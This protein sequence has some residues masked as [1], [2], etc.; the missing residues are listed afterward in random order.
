M[1]TYSNEARCTICHAGYDWKDKNYDFTKAGNVDCLSCHDTTGTYKKVFPAVQPDP[2]LDLAKLALSV[3]PTSRTSCGSCHFYGG[4]GDHIKHGDLDKSLVKPTRDIDVHM[5]GSSNMGC[6]AC[7]S[8]EKHV[9]KGQSML[10]S[11]G[12]GPRAACTDCHNDPKIHKNQFVEKHTKKVACQACHIP[13][14]AKSSPTK[15]WWDWSKAGDK[16]RKP[17]HD[18]FGMEDYI[19][20]KG[21]F[22]WNMNFMPEYFWYNGK[23]DRVLGGDK[24]DP[25]K[26]VKI[27]T[28]QGSRHDKNAKLMPFKVMRGKQPYD[29]GNNTLAYVQVFGGY[30]KHLDWQKAVTDGM[31][32]MDQPY[33][34]KYGFVETSM[35]WPVNHMVAPK[36]KALRCTACHGSHGKLNWKALGYDNDPIMKKK[37]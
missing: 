35:V 18:A 13:I 4:G 23:V 11:D 15:V 28:P 20:I 32:S 34:G 33:S 25:T 16:N 30:W 36:E 8:A 2:K 24:I 37:K 5:G 3:G 6:S 22:K 9:I 7:H 21:E 31:K 26:I 10:V 1:N 12:N 19:A 17:K 29:A 27:N 14:I